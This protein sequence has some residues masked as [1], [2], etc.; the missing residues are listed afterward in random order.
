MCYNLA[1]PEDKPIVRD[2]RMHGWDYARGASF[3]ITIATNP[4]KALFGRVKD[5]EVALSPLGRVVAESLAA[6]PHFNPAIRLFDSVVMPD[7][8]HFNVHVQ[9]GLERPLYVLGRAIGRFKNH[10]L[11]V[12][13]GWAGTAR[14]SSLGAEPGTARP[15]SLGAE[16]GTARPSSLGVELGT[17]RPSSLEC[18]AEDRAWWGWA[19]SEEGRAAL[20]HSFWQQGYHDRVCLNRAFIDAT[21]RYIRYNPLKWE[22]MHNSPDALRVHEPLDSMRLPPD[23]Y[24]KGVGNLA[25]LDADSKM[26]SLRVSRRLTA[27]APLLARMEKA[28]AQGYTVLSGFISP[29]EK[30]VRDLLCADAKARF[31]RILPSR[32]AN[33]EAYRPES[34]YVRAFAEGRY[35]EIARGNEDVDFGRAAC[36]DLNAAMV[37]IANA[38]EGLAIYWKQEGPHRLFPLAHEMEL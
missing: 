4:R 31:I 18:A 13:R 19:L 37:R 12:A 2:R 15:S 14:P 24:W 29:G 8:V 27:M 6:M 9:A 30:A 23:E 16:L 1:M 33:G 10:V 32:I 17:A 38:G 34:R 5:G 11:K 26:V 7:H 22:L 25:L 20:G 28:V 21:V 36:L 3:F 35:L